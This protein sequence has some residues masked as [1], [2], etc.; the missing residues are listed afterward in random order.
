TT[1]PTPTS[2]R[3]SPAADDRGTGRGKV[4]AMAPE[5]R[6]TG[7]PR[8]VTKRLDIAPLEQILL[9]AG[10]LFAELGFKQTTTRQIAEAAGLRQGSLYYY[11]KSKDDMLAEL[12]DRIA[13]RA[14]EVAT[15]V[16]AQDASA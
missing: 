13:E 16:V 9:E 8:V 10:R 14:L 1:T 4:S 11:F 3:S 12:L 2:H 6:R 7:R 15:W 5:P